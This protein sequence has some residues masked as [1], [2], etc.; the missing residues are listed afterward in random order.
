[1][2]V[3]ASYLVDINVINEDSV[4]NENFNFSDEKVLDN[5]KFIKFIF[6]F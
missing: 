4:E 2:W 6:I 3:P 1:M 5:G